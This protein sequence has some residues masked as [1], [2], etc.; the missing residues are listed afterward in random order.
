M[1]PYHLVFGKVCHLPIE[2]EHKVLWAL[3]RLNLNLEKAIEL[4]K[5]ERGDCVENRSAK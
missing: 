1:L 3:K 4:S 2:P 5:L